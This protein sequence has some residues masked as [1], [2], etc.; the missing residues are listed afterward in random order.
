[1]ATNN[2]VV[3]DATGAART[4]T[5]VDSTGSG[6]AIIPQHCVVDPTLT[7]T[8][9]TGDDVA[10]PIFVKPGD[11]THNTPSGDAAA[12]EI[13]VG[14]ADG[15]TGPAFITPASTGALATNK[16]L[17]VRPMCAT[18]GTNT[19]PAGDAI[20]RSLSVTPNDGT[21]A[22]KMASL[23]N[24]QAWTGTN[25][26]TASLPGQK[27]ATDSIVTGT[28]TPTATLTAP[29]ANKIFNVHTISISLACTAD[30]VP[31]LFKL[32]QDSGGTPVTLW[33]GTLSGLAKTC[34]SITL[35]GLSIPQTV[36]NKALD[37][38]VTAGTIVS[39]NYITVTVGASICV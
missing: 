18:D 13:F 12:R 23:A 38:S 4:V 36:A 21:T 24:L 11:G 27:V 31:L 39:T 30:Q 2:L 5:M 9:P 26:L 15:T 22:C 37:L 14:L 34:Q 3:R 16:A 29:G 8:M 6:G 35:T 1:M 28:T 19:T 17:V 20:A 25:A 10:R 32:I 7:Y 33:Q